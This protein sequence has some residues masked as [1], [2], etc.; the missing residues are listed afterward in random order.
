[1]KLRISY[2]FM[3]VVLVGA[4]WAGTHRNH[5]PTSD[6]RAQ[7]ISQTIMCPVCRGQS[8]AESESPAANDIRVEIARR[9]SDGESDAEIRD[10]FGQKLGADVLLRPTSKGFAGLVW[11]LPVVGFVLAAGGIAFA[12]FRWRRWGES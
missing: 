11:V 8:V 5:V 2:G 3:V 7:A 9:I 1:M 4:M 12:F 6:E 10:Y